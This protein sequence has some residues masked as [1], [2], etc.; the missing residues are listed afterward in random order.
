[1]DRSAPWESPGYVEAVKG[2]Q[3]AADHAERVDD[4]W[5]ER[6]YNAFVVY[7]ALHDEFTTEDVRLYSHWIETPPDLRAWGHIAL[8]AMRAGVV[9]K[10][11]LGRSPRREA[12]QA[13]IT[14]WKRAM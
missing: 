12:H 13:F 7:A 14:I 11:G 10:V 1:M 9:R 4:G 3:R 8:K 2:A 5:K 6:A